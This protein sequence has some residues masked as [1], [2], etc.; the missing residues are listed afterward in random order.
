MFG[1]DPDPSVSTARV[2]SRRSFGHAH[3]GSEIGQR[4]Q[5]PGKIPTEAKRE[6]ATANGY[7]F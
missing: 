4:G 3:E 1:V 5:G 2:G 7:E 6:R